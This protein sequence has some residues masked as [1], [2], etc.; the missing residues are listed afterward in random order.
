[1]AAALLRLRHGKRIWVDSCGLRRGEKVGAFAAQVMDELGADIA[2]H[3]P[4]S[5]DELEDTN[6][7][8]IITLSPEAHHRALEFTRTM[9][10]EV[11]YWPTFDPSLAQGSREQMLDE[12][13]QVRQALD[14]RIA[15]RFPHESFGKL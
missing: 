10:L 11:E 14:R 3:R 6:F 13:R 12:Y 1:M 7:D 8:L 5:F 4:K 15:E 9:A 2:K